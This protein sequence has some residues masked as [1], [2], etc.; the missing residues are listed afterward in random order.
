MSDGPAS[1]NPGAAAE[2]GLVPE[3]TLLRAKLLT[4]SGESISVEWFVDQPFWEVKEQ[5]GGLR[6]IVPKQVS[7][8]DTSC[9]ITYNYEFSMKYCVWARLLRDAREDFI[10]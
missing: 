5:F 10:K 2:R 6:P 3:R 1:P 9:F 7:D 8:L 4:A